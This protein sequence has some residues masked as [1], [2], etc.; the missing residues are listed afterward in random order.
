MT[1]SRP[2]SPLAPVGAPISSSSA[3]GLGSLLSK[4]TSVALGGPPLTSSWNEEFG[5]AENSAS[6]AL[7]GDG[8]ELSWGAQP[9]RTAGGGKRR[10][11][12]VRVPSAPADGRQNLLQS[13]SNNNVSYVMRGG[14]KMPK[15]SGA[16]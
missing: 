10:L 6:F 7:T 16:E 12:A 1:S 8:E 4:P 2:R 11:D 9:P 5:L 13:K 3:S 15:Q 14:F